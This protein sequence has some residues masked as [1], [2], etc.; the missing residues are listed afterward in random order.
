MM[1]ATGPAIKRRDTISFRPPPDDPPSGPCFRGRKPLVMSSLSR[2][3]SSSVGTKILVALTGLGF[4]A[5]LLTH[6][7][8]NLLVLVDPHGYNE[9]SHKLISNP[10][11]Y[12][13]EAGLVVL[14]LVH[15]F[16]ATMV[17]LRNREARGRGYALKRRA[18]HTS[19][20]S[21]ASSTMIVTGIW[22]LLFVV[23]HLK[24]FKFGPWYDTP[25]GMRDLSRLVHEVYREPL[26]VA[27]YVLSMGVV[28]MHLSW[29]LSSAFQSMCVEHSRYNGFIRGAG[30]AVAIV[31][32]AGF[33]LIPVVIY[34]GGRP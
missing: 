1:S 9:Y 24:T 22:L 2:F 28:G 30:L 20:K 18:G 6:L 31:M 34:F 33:A 17:T 26:H 11:I 29:G 12:I 19:R 25:D 8:A 15:A 7:A 10:L 16:K 23:V 3:L 14:F 27:F 13:A 32:A 21:L 5:F 4:A